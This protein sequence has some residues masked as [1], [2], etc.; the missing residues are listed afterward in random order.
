LKSYLENRKQKVELLHNKH[1][2]FFPNWRT[3][4]CG[5]PQGSILGPLLFL[6]CINDLP[7]EIDSAS[8]PILC[9]D[10]TGV[11]I[12]GNSVQDLQIK[13]VMILNCLS[14]WFTMSGL[15]LT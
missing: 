13:S 4:K 14:K 6:V 3:I 12:S 5:V 9:A 8:R 2:K 15:S 1:S 7:L 11:L 10:D